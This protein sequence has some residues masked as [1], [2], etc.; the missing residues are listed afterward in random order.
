MHKIG[1]YLKA[2]VLSTES[3]S[4]DSDEDDFVG[5]SQS[6]D[7]DFRKCFSVLIICMG[8]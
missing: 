3:G 4:S 7:N 8:V 2:S 1:G 6:F 5:R